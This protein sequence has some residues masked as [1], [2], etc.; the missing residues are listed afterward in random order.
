MKKFL[1]CLLVNLCASQVGW[2]FTPITLDSVQSVPLEGNLHHGL[3][4][5]TTGNNN[6]NLTYY[7]IQIKE[8]T[9]NPMYPAYAVYNSQLMPFDNGTLLNIPYRN[10]VL[11]LKVGTKYCLRARGI[12]GNQVTDWAEQCDVTL[13]AATGSDSDVD[14][15]GLSEQV[16]FQYGTDPNN[17][18]S[19][20]DGIDDGTE[21][22]NGGDPNLALFAEIIVHTTEID[23]GE[24]DALGQ[25]S[26]QQQYIEIENIGDDIAYL[27]AIGISPASNSAD[28]FH[29]G[30]YP[31]VLTNIAPQNTLRIPVSFLPKENGDYNA[32][33]QIDSSN[34]TTEIDDITLTGSFAGSPVCAVSTDVID[35]GTI[36]LSSSDVHLQ[37]FII[38]NT[39]R[40]SSSGAVEAYSHGDL[41]FSIVS[42]SVEFAPGLRAFLLP[43]D[44]DLTVPVIFVPR[45]TGDYNEE[46]QIHSP[47][48][49]TQIIQLKAHV[50]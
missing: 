44:R 32:T 31:S 4:V 46:L 21:V 48:C 25:K 39:D 10:G 40:L 2:A 18:D 3:A 26:N 23:F 6:P 33:V 24:G 14:G 43:E 19:D 20:G 15:D 49:T 5:Q 27:D 7:E 12:Y 16:E 29:L 42:D 47:D 22:A 50:D 45:H 37:E 34:A 30:D 11:A 36:A 1:L 28:V 8:D 38:Y 17:A 9:G 41:R 13:T 35:F